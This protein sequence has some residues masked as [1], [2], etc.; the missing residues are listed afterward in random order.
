MDESNPKK[1]I[2]D[3]YE[4]VNSIILWRIYDVLMLL[5][6]EHNSEAALKL[7]Q[8]HEKGVFLGPN[9]AYRPGE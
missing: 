1:T 6:V 8:M 5:L 3:E 7:T 4:V 2:N 9:P